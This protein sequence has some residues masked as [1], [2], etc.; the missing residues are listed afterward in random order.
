M[1]FTVMQAGPM[2]T[3]Q[4]KGRFGYMEYGIGQSGVM[5]ADAYDQANALAG[6]SENA[7]VLEMTLLG[8]ELMFDDSALIAYTGADMQ[9]S[10]D[11]I[12]MKRGKAYWV[13][14]G[15][16][17]RFGM[18][19]TGVRAYLAVAGGI[20][21]PL[22]MGSRSTN[23]KCRLGG[24]CGRKLEKGDRVKIFARE[25]SD[26]RIHKLL[27]GEIMQKDYKNENVVRVVAGPQE[28]YFTEKG[29][30]TFTEAAYVISPDSDRMGIRM[31][32]PVIEG[33][34]KMDIVSDGI[35]F[36]SVQITSAGQPIVM[37]A[38]HQ[39]TGGYA[40]I[41]TVIKEDLPLL[42]QARP[43]DR[44]RFQRVEITDIQKKKRWR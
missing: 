34:D 26:R 24:F 18:A 43:G 19:R 31:D 3:V 28:D 30:Q 12:A 36:G 4:D 1:G 9:A 23:I 8:P 44:V 20:D 38:D 25:D 22:I 11:G 39:T 10:I 21:V 35:V 13:S 27:T 29:M 14:E 17:V 15:Q 32:G 33:R 42:A 6:N 40:K 41:A 2:T 7:A 16:K 37:M 5:D